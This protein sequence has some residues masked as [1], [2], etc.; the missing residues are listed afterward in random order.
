MQP[1]EAVD[2]YFDEDRDDMNIDS[3][4]EGGIEHTYEEKR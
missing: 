1:S 4:T 3:E 2:I